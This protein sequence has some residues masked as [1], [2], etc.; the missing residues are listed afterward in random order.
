MCQPEQP[1]DNTR[2]HKHTNWPVFEFAVPRELPKYS[3]KAT[4]FAVLEESKALLELLG[5]KWKETSQAS[6]VEADTCSRLAAT[7]DLFDPWIVTSSI[8]KTVLQL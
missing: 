2:T 5:N 4:Q 6:Q 7:N 1:L 3:P 8:K